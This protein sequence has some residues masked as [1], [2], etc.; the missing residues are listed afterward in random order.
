[1][2]LSVRLGHLLSQVPG[3]NG[4]AKAAA[5]LSALKVDTGG[6][7]PS[8][9]HPEGIFQTQGWISDA[10]SQMFTECFPCTR[11]C[12]KQLIYCISLDPHSSPII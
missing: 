12:A 10:S 6:C 1:M 8:R 7:S 3:P 9:T 2:T 11:D 4:E 5:G